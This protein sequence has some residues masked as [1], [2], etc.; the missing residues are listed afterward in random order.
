[1]ET[2]SLKRNSM[3]H[4]LINTMLAAL[5]LVLITTLGTLALFF[6]H[7]TNNFYGVGLSIILIFIVLSFISYLL[8]DLYDSLREEERDEQGSSYRQLSRH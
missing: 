7:E 8:Y 5:T 6:S 4:P 3:K 1:M 2:I